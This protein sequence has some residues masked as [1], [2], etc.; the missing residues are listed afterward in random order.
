[1]DEELTKP[2]MVILVDVVGGGRSL[3]GSGAPAALVADASL[4]SSLL[5]E[6]EGG[7]AETLET[8]E[9]TMDRSTV[10]GGCWS[11]CSYG[12]SRWEAVHSLFS[13]RLSSP[14]AGS[15]FD[16]KSA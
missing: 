14:G 12:R 4:T 11:A 16:S 9:E 8:T 6:L 2:W 10:S 1:V 5:D 7:D 13:F 15:V 3:L